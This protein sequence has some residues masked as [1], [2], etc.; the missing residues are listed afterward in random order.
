MVEKFQCPGCVAGSNTKCGRY[1]D[2][3]DDL[4]LGDDDTDPEAGNTDATATANNNPSVMM[5]AQAKKGEAKVIAGVKK[6]LTRRAERVCRTLMSN[7]LMDRPTA[8]EL[9]R[10]L[11][12]AN[13][14]LTE[15]GDVAR[16]DLITKLET[17]ESIAKKKVLKAKGDTGD[18]E[19][20]STTGVV[21]TPHLGRGAS[22]EGVERVKTL[23]VS[24]M[25]GA[26]KPKAG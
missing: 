23:M 12:G 5:S 4:D 17:Y 11:S 15:A 14:S 21:Q 10:G 13:L 22:A 2:G 7:G 19:F 24:R 8:Q 18:A 16:N 9:I 26:P 3:G 1:K 25:R 6:D 20:L